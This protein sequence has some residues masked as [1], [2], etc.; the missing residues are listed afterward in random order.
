MPAISLGYTFGQ[1]SKGT[2]AILDYLKTDLS[3]RVAEIAGAQ[4]KIEATVQT[5]LDAASGKTTQQL[6]DAQ[7]KSNKQLADAQTKTTQ[8]LAQQKKEVD[9]KISTLTQSVTA[10][11]KA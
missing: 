8:Q 6:A 10:D 5:N 7:T 2:S 1:Q 11:L 3:D 9:T 4:S